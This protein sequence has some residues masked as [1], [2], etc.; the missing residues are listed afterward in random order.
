MGKPS[1]KDIRIYKDYVKGGKKEYILNQGGRMGIFFAVTVFFIDFI[2]D[3]VGSSWEY[4]FIGAFFGLFTGLWG[5]HSIN[6][7]IKEFEGKGK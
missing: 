4:I 1:Q 6:K 5:W 7:K 3:D 2:G